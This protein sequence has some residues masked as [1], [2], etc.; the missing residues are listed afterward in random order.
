MATPK[1]KTNH[2]VLKRVL[3]GISIGVNILFLLLIISFK[4]GF[5]DYQIARYTFGHIYTNRLTE[6]GQV[7]S[8]THC[9][10][11]NKLVAGRYAYDNQGHIVLGDKVNCLKSFAADPDWS[12]VLNK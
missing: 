2:I 12:S 4:I 9:Y 11:L 5:W 10:A 7:Y 1:S 6:P 3:I 8:D